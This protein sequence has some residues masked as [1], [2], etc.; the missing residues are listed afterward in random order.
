MLAVHAAE[1]EDRPLVWFAISE[2][3]RRCAAVEVA[4]DPRGYD[5]TPWTFATT[6]E[7][8]RLDIARVRERIAAGDTYQ[9]NLTTRLRARVVGSLP[10]YYADLIARQ[11]PRYAAYV[12]T[13]TQVLLSASPELFFEWRGTRVLTRPMK[14]T[15]ARGRYLDEDDVRRRRLV[16]SAKERAENIIVVDLLRNDLG[17]IATIGTVRADRLCH[18]E[19]YETVWQLTSDVGAEVPEDASLVSLFTALFPSGS[20]T[21]APKPATMQIIRDLEPRPRGVYCGAV[22]WVAPPDRPTRA[23]FNVAIR[24]VTVDRRDNAAVYGVGGGITWGSAPD[25]EFAELQTKAAILDR[26]AADTG[27]GLIETMALHGTGIRNRDAHVDRLAAS[28]RYFGFAFDRRAVDAALD[29][30]VAA[31]ADARVRLTL[32]RCGAVTVDTGALPQPAQRPVTVA[33]DTEPIDSTQPWPFHKTTRREPYLRRAARHDTGDVVL[34][35]ERGHVTE[36]TIANLAVRLGE[37]WW[38]PPLDDGCLPGIERAR[39]LAAG[40]MR[41]R[42]LTPADLDRA[43][44]LALVS[45]LRGWRPAML[46]A[47]RASMQRDGSSLGSQE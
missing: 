17:R 28:A 47:G 42:V 9:V 34:V 22:G 30:V 32:T 15:A 46:A 38:T 21:G 23:R 16:A 10:A 1:D 31:E 4:D 39:L 6:A 45:S 29:E 27:F 18:P 41:E 40:R 43:C 5:V 3:P 36:T 26:R 8:H 12:D 25:R 11:R 35:N 20:V 14:G 24:T 7:Q 2:A 13:G 19:R 33:V 37:S 44:A